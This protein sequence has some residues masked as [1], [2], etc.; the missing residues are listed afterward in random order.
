M[1][2]RKFSALMLSIILAAASVG[3]AA[4]AEKTATDTISAGQSA[5]KDVI[6]KTAQTVGDLIDSLWSTGTAA[7]QNASASWT[8]S[9]LKAAQ[10][11][12]TKVASASYDKLRLSW[13]PLSGVDGYQIYRAT[14]KSGKYA[15]I[16]TV[17]GA[18]SA[19]YT[20]TGRTCGT[21]YYYKLRA[22]KKI[23][24]K[25]VYSK[26][27]A[28]LS[29]YAKPAKVKVT[30]AYAPSNSTEAIAVNFTTVRGATDY[31][32]QVNKIKNGKETG[33]RSYTY[34][35]E[36]EK[37]TFETYKQCLAK[38]KKKYPSGYVTK[39][40]MENGKHLTKKMTVEK[41]TETL[42]GKNQAEIELVQDDSIYEFRVRAYRSVNGRKVY[43]SWSEPYTLKETLNLDEIFKELRQYMIDY[44]A[45]NEPRWH[46]DDSRTEAPWEANYYSDGE[47]AGFS[48]YS[49]QDEVIARYKKSIEVYLSQVVKQGGSETG[50]LYL[51]RV[52][53]GEQQD[54]FTKSEG[55]E[56]Y[57]KGF[58]LW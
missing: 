52:A 27:S 33:F 39:A 12:F 16:A 17:K 4:A 37:W 24:G 5:A 20:N 7:D 57:Y 34:N 6:D 29:A 8:S 32:A 41:F 11:D 22:Y 30:D 42:I 21:R 9:K 40:Y 35:N 23:G 2:K 55:P 18:S 31:E 28:I 54:A 58:F 51:F 43:G 44:A 38:M 3:F 15:K 49:K 19:T 14:S 25:T 10:V 36:G 47:W 13:E 46:Y 53:P 50:Y 56:T 45:K 48:I 26:Y 1:K